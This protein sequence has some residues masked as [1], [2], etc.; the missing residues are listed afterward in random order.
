MR[1]GP[2]LEKIS[3]LR[4]GF[5]AN[6]SLRPLSIL[7]GNGGLF[8]DFEMERWRDGRHLTGYAFPDMLVDVV[9][10]AQQ[11]RRDAAR[12]VCSTPIFR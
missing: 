11:G 7:A 12:R 2:G 8:L 5:P 9:K 1:I 10:D 6:G 3:T 4:R